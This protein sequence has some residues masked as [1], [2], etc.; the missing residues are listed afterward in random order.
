[1]LLFSP[2]WLFLIP[3]ILSILI[4]A[5]LGIRIYMGTFEIGQFRL[6]INT[7]IYSGA[8]ILIG[9]Q[10]VCFA[11]F[12]KVFAIQEGLMKPDLRLNKIFKVINL[13]VGLVI[14]LLL[15]IAGGSAFG[16]I[17]SIWKDTGFSNMNPLES[18]RIVF[19]SAMA[20]VLGFQIIFSSFFL[21]VLGLKL[22]RK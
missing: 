12:S 19:P 17:L 16:R 6:D 5:A 2:R 18:V 15:I 11:V 9:F 7:M 4:G 22:D 21:S 20:F 14:G 13:E 3:G 1:M 10:S 8:L